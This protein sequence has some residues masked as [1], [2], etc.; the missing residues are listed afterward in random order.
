[1]LVI[2][3]DGAVPDGE[4]KEVDELPEDTDNVEMADV[5]DAAVTPDAVAVFP[6]SVIVAQFEDEGA[7]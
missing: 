7:G 2:D 6:R 4:E 1:M 3:V 5:V